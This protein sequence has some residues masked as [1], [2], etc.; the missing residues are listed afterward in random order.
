M[1]APDWQGGTRIGDALKSFNRHWSRR[2]LGQGA[3]VLLVTDGLERGDISVLRVEAERL[4]RSCRRLIW[5]NPLLRWEQFSPLAAGV[6]ALLPVVDSF[7]ACH[8]LDS[9]SDLSATLSSTGEK[10]RFA[11]PASIE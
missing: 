4:S 2:I 6:R 11:G 7:H 8:S 5:L 1:K 10:K 9:L 3:V